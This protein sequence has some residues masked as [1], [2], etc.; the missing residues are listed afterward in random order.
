L[1]SNSDLDLRKE[2]VALSG[3]APDLPPSV[4]LRMATLG[5]ARALGLD[6][7]IGSFELGKEARLIAITAG[8]GTIHDPEAFVLT[9][10]E[11]Q[12]VTHLPGPPY[13]E[14]R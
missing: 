10:D 14:G 12:H 4:I 2:M 7:R 1:A 5:G 9:P 6:H 13:I 11:H 8:A 3:V